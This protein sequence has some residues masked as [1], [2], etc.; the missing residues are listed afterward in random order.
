MIPHNHIF[1][2]IIFY[3]YFISQVWSLASFHRNIS[4]THASL[5]SSSFLIRKRS[6]TNPLWNTAGND[7]TTDSIRDEI[8]SLKQK[9]LQKLSLLDETLYELNAGKRDVSSTCHDRTTRVPE[10]FN[11]SFGT[12]QERD[13]LESEQEYMD[14]RLMERVAA[15]NDPEV[16]G[17]SSPSN[18]RKRDEMLLDGT[19][20]KISLDIG[21]EG[22]L[23]CRRIGV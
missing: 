22:V 8:E 17:I 5:R 13:E 1:K 3:H 7:D 2:C 19:R 18:P 10:R 16:S 14:R 11:T 12:V 9:A 4:P 23:G 21:R 15:S 20:W 6:T